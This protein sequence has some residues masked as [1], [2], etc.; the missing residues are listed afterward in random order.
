MSSAFQTRYND[1]K[2]AVEHVITEYAKLGIRTRQCAI[3]TSDKFIHNLTPD[4]RALTDLEVELFPNCWTPLEVKSTPFCNWRNFQD[5][6]DFSLIYWFD[7]NGNSRV[8]I[9]KDI[10]FRGP[11]QGKS[12]SKTLYI[13]LQ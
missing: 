8:G 12:N 2:W 13:I 10:K 7:M 6:P 5:Y 3:D 11:Y 1:S 4:Q 9:K